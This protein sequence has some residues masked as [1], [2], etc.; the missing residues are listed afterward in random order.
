MRLRCRIACI[1]CWRIPVEKNTSAL[2]L[3]SRLV[4]QVITLSFVPRIKCVTLQENE[5]ENCVYEAPL[6]SQS[7]APTCG[8]RAINAACHQFQISSR[9][10][11]TALRTS[12]VLATKTKG[13]CK[14]TYVRQDVVAGQRT[15]RIIKTSIELGHH[16]VNE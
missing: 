3:T 6:L 16:T 9:T 13:P 5:K 11:H 15:Q 8:S 4:Q 7:Y 10:F 2:F 12:A 14:F 1:A